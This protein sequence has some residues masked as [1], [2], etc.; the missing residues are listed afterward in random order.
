MSYF[1]SYFILCLSAKISLHFYEFLLGRSIKNKFGNKLYEDYLRFMN[2][3]CSLSFR[4]VFFLTGPLVV[5][6][7]VLNKSEIR[8]TAIKSHMEDLNYHE[9]AKAVNSLDDV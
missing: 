3:K 5:L 4:L 9:L 2:I 6:S 8:K 1:I 7:W